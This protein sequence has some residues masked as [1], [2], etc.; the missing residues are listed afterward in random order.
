MKHTVTSFCK[1]ILLMT[2]ENEKAFASRVL[3]QIRIDHKLQK[4]HR[5]VANQ[6]LFSAVH[7]ESDNNKR[8]CVP[9]VAQNPF[10]G[11]PSDICIDCLVFHKA[12]SDRS[13]FKKAI[14]KTNC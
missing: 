6:A 1:Q 13:I 5:R 3:V 8:L 14:P 10:L 2:A 4:A 12:R 11:K 9:L 7:P